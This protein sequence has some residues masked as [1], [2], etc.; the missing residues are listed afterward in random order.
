[1]KI[2]DNGETRMNPAAIQE[3]LFRTLLTP[4]E[5]IPHRFPTSP[6]HNLRLL[7]SADY[8]RSV[9]GE[10]KFRS[11]TVL[12]LVLY[13]FFRMSSTF[14]VKNVGAALVFGAVVFGSGSDPIC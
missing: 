12:A 9:L 5:A 13:F 7:L 6:I 1:M 11:G 3:C 4:A 10:W 2:R 8:L 14:R